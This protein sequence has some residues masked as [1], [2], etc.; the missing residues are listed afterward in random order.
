MQRLVRRAGIA[1]GWHGTPELV[2]HTASRFCLLCHPHLTSNPCAC[3][4]PSTVNEL[5]QPLAVTGDEEWDNGSSSSS[6]E[7][8]EDE[9]SAELF[10]GPGGPASPAARPKSRS[11]SDAASQASARAL[12]A[13]V[14]SASGGSPL[15][16][17]SGAV[18]LPL[19]ALL[20]LLSGNMGVVGELISA[21]GPGTRNR[22]RG[23]HRPKPQPM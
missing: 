14:A 1:R 20:K 7:E 19:A 3:E 13:F 22:K 15:P 9:V 21:L 2:S 16:S 6:D 10:G 8:E 5:E 18:Q 17:Q 11:S 12:D 4:Q 23:R